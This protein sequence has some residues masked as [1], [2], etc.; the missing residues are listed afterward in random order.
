MRT[1]IGVISDSHGDSGHLQQALMKLEAGGRLDALIHCGDHASDADLIG[2]NILQVAAVRGN[3]DGWLDSHEEEML[4]NIGGVT[5]FIAHGHR[6]GVKREADTIA[7]I[8]AARGA[9]I[10]CFGHTHVPLCEYC[11][12]VLLLNPGA[13]LYTGDCALI[14]TDGRGGYSVQ[15][16]CRENGTTLP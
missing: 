12:G 3:C 13:C 5:F 15:M 14:T 9:Q 4:L 2:A 7:E 11:R 16:L 8:A 10:C 6:Y 1:R